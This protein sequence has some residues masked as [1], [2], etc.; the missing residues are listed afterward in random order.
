ML[1]KEA[2][3]TVR[4]GHAAGQVNLLLSPHPNS[5]ADLLMGAVITLQEARESALSLGRGTSLP[6]G[7]NAGF[8]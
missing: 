6:G 5:E 3:W 8:L 7:D 1:P 2:P 4:P